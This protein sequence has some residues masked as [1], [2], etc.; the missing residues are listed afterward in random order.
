MIFIQDI[1]FIMTHEYKLPLLT[2]FYLREFFWL[3]KEKEKVNL[4][5]ACKR[6]PGLL[7]NA[8]KPNVILQFVIRS[9][10]REH[11]YQD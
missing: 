8:A 7:A 11:I 2:S 6:C 1:G 5:M 4:R 10:G 3:D 9:G